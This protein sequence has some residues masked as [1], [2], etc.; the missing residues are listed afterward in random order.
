MLDLRANELTVVIPAYNAE[1]TVGRAVSSAWECGATRVLVVDDASTDSTAEVA[2]T[3]GADVYVQSKNQGAAEARTRGVRGV[4]T[5]FVLLLDADDGICPSGVLAATDLLGEQP[6]IGAV[7][8]PYVVRSRLARAWPE[9]ISLESLLA[10]GHSPG[11][12][13][14][15]VWRTA[16]LN[17]VL[18]ANWP[19]LWPRFAEDYEV[20]VRGAHLARFGSVD[21]VGAVYEEEGGKSHRD[22]MASITSAEKIRI[23]Y[24]VEFG[25]TVRRR[26]RLQLRT[27]SLRRRYSRSPQVI[28]W[29]VS[30]YSVL[31]EPS[32]LF[33]RLNSAST[34]T[35]G[36]SLNSVA[37]G[38]SGFFAVVVADR[39]AN[40]RDP[41]S[42]IILLSLRIA[43]YSL[44]R[45]PAPIGQMVSIVHRLLTEIMLGTELRPKTQVGP[46][47]TIYHGFGL[48]VNDGV[49]I[50]RSVTLRNGVV[51]GNSEP[52]SRV[53]R[54]GDSVVV[55]ANACIIGDIEVG[56]G[57]I[58]GAGAVV[59]RD[60]PAGSVVAGNPA[61]VIRS[62]AGEKRA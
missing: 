12:P 57:A 21:K 48:V 8:M 58:V 37:Y 41:R 24:A 60:V 4:R 42:R 36:A 32:L 25:M 52:G 1:A 11:P 45:H 5:E 14:S 44:A 18:D 56:E 6:S 61:R 43:Q 10:R 3:L 39:R 22:P 38:E 34:P 35:E 47:L 19:G 23:T 31:V 13:A 59:V 33:R 2:A 46:G 53:P 7:F 55:G 51:I 50:G 30:F 9:G 40:P 26:N 28:R 54:I 49:V 29:L 16:I 27:M 20:L 17:R 15:F 62:P